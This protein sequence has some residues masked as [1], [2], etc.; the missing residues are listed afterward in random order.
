MA[1]SEK[2]RVLVVFHSHEGNTR[3]LAENIADEIGADIEELVP[4]RT[5]TTGPMKYFWR[6]SQVMMGKKPQ[7]KPLKADPRTYDIIFLGSPVWAWTYTPPVNT[8]LSTH[9]LKG[10]KVAIFLSC[11]GGPGKTLEKMK[12]ALKGNDL[13]GEEWFFAPLKKDTETTLKRARDWAKGLMTK[14]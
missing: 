7:I 8:F 2:K 9:G 4:E 5:V 12:E 11:E 10:K 14:V 1:A 13:L 6:E 3:S